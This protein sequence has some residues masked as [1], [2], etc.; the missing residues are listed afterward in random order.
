MFTAWRFR[1][2]GVTLLASP[3]R[4]PGSH[5]TDSVVTDAQ[6]AASHA[7]VLPT[8][9]DVVMRTVLMLCFVGWELALHVHRCG[10]RAVLSFR[11]CVAASRGSPQRSVPR[12]GPAGAYCSGHQVSL[13]SNATLAL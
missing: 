12:G 11:T 10:P 4:P 9:F 5:V 6:N 7:H 8:P 2:M 1:C 3:T 13:H